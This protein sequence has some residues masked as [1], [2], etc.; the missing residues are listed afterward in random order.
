MRPHYFYDPCKRL[1]DV[2]TSITLLVLLLPLLTVIAF[3]VSLDGGTIFF[4]QDRLGF[5]GQHFKMW[6]FRSM[7]P[8]AD[9]KLL[10]MLEQD[11]A[12]REYWEVWRKLPNDPRTTAVG[13]WLR[14]LSLDELPQLW[15]VL[16]GE[17]SMVG[18]RPIL[19]NEVALWGE[20]LSDYQQVRPGITGLWQVSGR[21]RLSYEERITLDLIYID[22][23]GAW[24]DTKILVRTVGVVVAIHGAH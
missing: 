10:Q 17:M 4:T 5:K 14:R 6:K 7:I 9:A 23:R 22:G 1:F 24:L 13:T 15:N 12:Q 20:R 3:V 19:P 11:E 21:S 16:K 2:V 18:P 8:N